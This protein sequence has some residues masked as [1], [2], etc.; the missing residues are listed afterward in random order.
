METEEM[1]NATELYEG[2]KRNS[3]FAQLEVA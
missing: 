2:A 1:A 3:L